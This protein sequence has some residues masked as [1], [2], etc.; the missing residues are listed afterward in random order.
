VEKTEVGTIVRVYA[1]LDGDPTSMPKYERDDENVRRA[2]DRECAF[3]LLNGSYRLQYSKD[4]DSVER[5]AA[6]IVFLTERIL[7]GCVLL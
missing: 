4:R 2:T 7:Q 1:I 6:K 3:K 5:T